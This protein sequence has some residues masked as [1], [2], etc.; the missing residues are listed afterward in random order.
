MGW[1]SLLCYSESKC[2]L[3]SLKKL[4]RHHNHNGWNCIITE[5]SPIF[6]ILPSACFHSHFDSL[7]ALLAGLAVLARAQP[8][9]HS[10]MC[11]SAASSA[12]KPGTSGKQLPSTQPC[13]SPR[14]P[15][16]SHLVSSMIPATPKP[17]AGECTHLDRPTSRPSSR[18]SS[19]ES[20][21]RSAPLP[22][23]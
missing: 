11:L 7:S 5:V 17:A 1:A 6:E 12:S 9:S 19:S 22:T 10:R 13:L 16:R 8:R 18:P 15:S 23:L 2:A 14:S 21:M 20:P 3:Q 4:P